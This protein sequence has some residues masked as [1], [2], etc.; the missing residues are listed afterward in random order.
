MGVGLQQE[1][2]ASWSMWALSE[3]DRCEQK[4]CG[5][6]GSFMVWKLALPQN[7]NQKR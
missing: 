5:G 2:G 7:M 6:P 1:L 4:G 3:K